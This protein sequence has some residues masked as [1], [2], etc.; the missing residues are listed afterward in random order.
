MLDFTE[1]PARPNQQPFC[2][3]FSLVL[4]IIAVAF[5]IHCCTVRSA[6]SRIFFF[7]FIS[8]RMPNGLAVVCTNLERDCVFSVVSCLRRGPVQLFHPTIGCFSGLLRLFP[9]GLLS[10]GR[11][12]DFF[13]MA[14]FFL[15]PVLRIAHALRLDL[16]VTNV[17][18]FGMI[19]YSLSLGVSSRTAW[20]FV[21]RR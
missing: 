15:A 6:L 13:E 7:P 19:V 12:F 21:W 16:R 1:V 11:R 17:S 20:R 3:I 10:S 14:I 5:F 8:T 18:L 4:S 9:F 2:R